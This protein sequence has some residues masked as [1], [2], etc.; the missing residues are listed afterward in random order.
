[1]IV[2]KQLIE[3]IDAFCGHTGYARSTVSNHLFGNGNEVERIEKGG[4]IGLGIANRTL[5]WLSDRWPADRPWPAGIERP[6][7]HPPAN[8]PPKR[9]RP[10]KHPLGAAV[11]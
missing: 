9:G 10:R 1:M 11:A 2:E 3:L 7:P 6:P 8:W 4:T 5:Q